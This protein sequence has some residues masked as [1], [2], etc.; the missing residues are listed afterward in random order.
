MTAPCGPPW[1]DPAHRQV[2]ERR[3]KGLQS[4]PS[5]LLHPKV[6]EKEARKTPK[7]DAIRQISIRLSFYLLPTGFPLFS[8]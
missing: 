7:F 8:I 3:S 4:V 6:V 2:V 1:F 5:Q